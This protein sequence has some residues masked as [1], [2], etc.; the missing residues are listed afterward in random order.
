MLCASCADG[1]GGEHFFSALRD[2]ASPEELYRRILAVPQGQTRPDQWQ[3]QILVKILR[4]HRVIFVSE[5]EAAPLL[6]QMK[7]EYAPTLEEAM[8]RAYAQKGSGA[9][10]CVI[11]DGVAVAVEPPQEPAREE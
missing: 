10:L 1:H 5:P 8:A 7:L 9:R 11:P 6:T 3:V 4:E 2:C